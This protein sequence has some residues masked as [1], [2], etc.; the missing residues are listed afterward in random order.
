MPPKRKLPAESSEPDVN[1]NGVMIPMRLSDKLKLAGACFEVE[2]Q[3]A[4]NK[5]TEENAKLKAEMTENEAEYSKVL[6]N[7]TA[8]MD[9]QGE[10]LAQLTK[11]AKDRKLDYEI[12]QEKWAKEKAFLEEMIADQVTEMKNL[13]EKI[14]KE[15]SGKCFTRMHA[16][17]EGTLRQDCS[18]SELMVLLRMIAKAD[19]VTLPVTGYVFFVPPAGDALLRSAKKSADQIG[20]QML[21]QIFSDKE[22]VRKMRDEGLTPSGA[23]RM[24]PP[25]PITPSQESL[26]VPPN[27]KKDEQDVKES[28]PK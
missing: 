4:D 15:Y 10:T 1:I 14:R 27:P 28:G 20:A 6:A 5:L 2:H 11:V 22:M 19:P 7:M 17:L 3:N 9:K 26:L 23:L 25:A 18:I 24:L 13:D 16:G 21:G 12:E 8:M